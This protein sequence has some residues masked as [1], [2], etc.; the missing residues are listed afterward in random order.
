MISPIIKE[1]SGSKRKIPTQVDR[2][3]DEL[4]GMTVDG[5]SK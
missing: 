3:D 4:S 1:R 2:I 5:V